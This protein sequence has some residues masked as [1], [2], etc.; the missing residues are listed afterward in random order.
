MEKQLESVKNYLLSI[1]MIDFGSVTITENINNWPDLSWEAFSGE[2][3][4]QNINLELSQKRDWENLFYIEKER[5]ITIKKEIFKL[6]N[7]TEIRQYLNLS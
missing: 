1:L 6:Q 3:Y 7:L 4:E 2:L 5:F